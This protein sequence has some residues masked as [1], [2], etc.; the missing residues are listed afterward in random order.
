MNYHQIQNASRTCGGIVLTH[1]SE[2]G[3]FTNGSLGFMDWRLL[4]CKKPWLSSELS[5][6][7][8]VKHGT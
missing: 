7:S 5:V 3:L 1:L 2:S 6:R 8:E 4:V